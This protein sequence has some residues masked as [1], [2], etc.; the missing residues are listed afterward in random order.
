[1]ILSPKAVFKEDDITINQFYYPLKK[2]IK[3]EKIKIFLFDTFKLNSLTS[4][5]EFLCR[6]MHYKDMPQS[7]FVVDKFNIWQNCPLNKDTSIV[8]CGT[9]SFSMASKFIRFLLSKFKLGIDQVFVN[10][11]NFNFINSINNTTFTKIKYELF[12][13]EDEKITPKVTVDLKR[14]DKFIE[15]VRIKTNIGKLKYRVFVK[16]QWLNWVD[17]GEETGIDDYYIKGFQFQYVDDRYTLLYQCKLNGKYTKYK[18]ICKDKEFKFYIE[19]LKFK[20]EG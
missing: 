14:K 3:P 2:E 9:E 6:R 4:F 7:T 13:E 17:N 11:D 18:E 15:K 1:M 20:L 5:G 10:F 12:L 19:D 16:G 8:L